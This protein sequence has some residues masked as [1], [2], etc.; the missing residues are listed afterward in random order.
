ME[1]SDYIQYADDVTQ[2]I[3][4]PGPPEAIAHNTSIAIA[5]LNNFENNWKIQT[6]INKF[7]IVNIARKENWE[8]EG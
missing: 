8:R 6:N 5:D 3:G 2:I 1:N 7:K 4:L